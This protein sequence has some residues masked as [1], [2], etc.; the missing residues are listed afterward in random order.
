MFKHPWGRGWPLPPIVPRPQLLITPK[1]V[2]FKQI[3]IEN[4]IKVHKLVPPNQH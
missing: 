1:I 2:V 3:Y 4:C